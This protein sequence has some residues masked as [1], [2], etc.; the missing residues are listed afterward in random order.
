MALLFD[1]SDFDSSCSS[2]ISLTMWAG[3]EWEGSAIFE[4]S[5][6]ISLSPKFLQALEFQPP[7]L[8]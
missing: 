1:S 2:S 7:D 5:S 4:V 8:Q 3:I 6:L